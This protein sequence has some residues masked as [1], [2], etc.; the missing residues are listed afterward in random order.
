MVNETKTSTDSDLTAIIQKVKS[1]VMSGSKITSMAEATQYALV[2]TTIHVAN[3]ILQQEAT[4]L[5]AVHD[6]FRPQ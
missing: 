3:T 4:L 6:Y 1:E 5:P 2:K